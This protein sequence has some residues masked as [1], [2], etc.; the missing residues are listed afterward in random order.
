MNLFILCVCYEIFVLSYLLKI[1]FYYHLKKETE[2]SPNSLFTVTLCSSHP[3]FYL[4]FLHCNKK[5]YFHEF[6]WF[7]VHV[8]TSCDILYVA[9][10]FR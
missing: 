7:N 6:L 3:T 2:Y 8:R 4:L 5:D 10:I 1:F 9:D